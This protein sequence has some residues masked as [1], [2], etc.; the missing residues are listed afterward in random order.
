MEVEESIINKGLRPMRC[1]PPAR[2]I[3]LRKKRIIQ[4]GR[5][6][7]PEGIHPS[8]PTKI[9]WHPMKEDWEDVPLAVV[10]VVVSKVSLGEASLSARGVVD[11]IVL[12]VNHMENNLSVVVLQ[13]VVLAVDL[14]IPWEVKAPVVVREA[15]KKVVV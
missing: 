11:Q 2:K 12:Q 1:K 4:M 15:L 10:L 13:K 8:S 6:V 3:S 5:K 9:R 7:D 14:V